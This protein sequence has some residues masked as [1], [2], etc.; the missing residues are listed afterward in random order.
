MDFTS[1][2]ITHIFRLDRSVGM[3]M[4]LKLVCSADTGRVMLF[5]GFENGNVTA[6]DLNAGRTVSSLS[7]HSDSVMCLDVDS[8]L[9]GM[10]GSA[11]STLCTW[12]LDS[13]MLRLEKEIKAR[14]PGF[15]CIKI[16]GDKTIVAMGGWDGQVRVYGWKKCKPLAVLSY[17]EE[18]LH[19]LDFRDTGTE[20]HLLASG[21]NDGVLSVW[22]LY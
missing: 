5:G 10:S 11:D 14:N 13:G 6:W 15:S 1:N 17:H 2:T 20:P 7:V 3:P 21:S 9:K 19:S 16:R 4:C 12:K 18:T 22:S 8:S